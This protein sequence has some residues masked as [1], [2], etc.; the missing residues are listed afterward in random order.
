MNSFLPARQVLCRRHIET[1]AF[2]E[3]RGDPEESIRHAL[4]ECSVAK[5]LWRQVRIG[6]GVK[7]PNLNPTTW[8][9]DLISGICTKR[10]TT[11]ILCGMWALWMMRNKR[12][13]GEQPM[14]VQ[15]AVLW[16]RDTACI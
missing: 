13:H 10:D 15:Q 3:E 11:I 7:I 8:A 9:A 6:I 12:H 16:A 1:I 4:L 14:S 2:C 5:E